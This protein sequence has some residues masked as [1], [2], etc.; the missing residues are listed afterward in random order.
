MNHVCFWET[1]QFNLA[2]QSVSPTQHTFCRHQYPSQSKSFR[3]GRDALSFQTKQNTNYYYYKAHLVEKESRHDS[4]KCSEEWQKKKRKK[5]RQQLVGIYILS[6]STCTRGSEDHFFYHFLIC[7]S[8]VCLNLF[9]IWSILYYSGSNYPRF[10]L[11]LLILNH[12]EMWNEE[13]EV[14]SYELWGLEW[15][16]SPQ[17]RALFLGPQSLCLK[18]GSWNE[19]PC[20]SYPTSD[21]SAS[22]FC[23][24][25]IVTIFPH[26]VIVRM[27]NVC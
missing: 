12:S 27:N 25:V 9:F 3:A 19:W 11:Y 1:H 24:T 6:I 18:S 8:L 14:K 15:D 21:G 13:E 7:L 20:V 5:C 4:G 22:S 17:T 2:I 10:L 16:V 23:H 26:G